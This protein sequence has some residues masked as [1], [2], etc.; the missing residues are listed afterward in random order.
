[1]RTLK[2]VLLG[3]GASALLFGSLAATAFAAPAP[4]GA[5]HGAFANVNGNFGWLGALGGTPGYH[6]G[7]VGQDVGATG[8]NNSNTDCQG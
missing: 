8:Y 6:D 2:K 5:T 4:C 7:A 3:A 1:M